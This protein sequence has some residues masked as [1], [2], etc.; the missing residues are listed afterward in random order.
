MFNRVMKIKYMPVM[1]IIICF[2]FL[3]ACKKEEPKVLT[4][5]ETTTQKA[6]TMEDVLAG[7]EKQCFNTIHARFQWS[8]GEEYIDIQVAVN[9]L[10]ENRGVLK[11]TASFLK[12]DMQSDSGHLTTVLYDNGNFYVNQKEICDYLMAMDEQFIVITGFF[13]AAREYICITG[14]DIVSLLEENGMQQ[15][16]EKFVWYMNQPPG[17]TYR[18]IADILVQFQERNP[19]FCLTENHA[20]LEADK[21]ELEEIKTVLKEMGLEVVFPQKIDFAALEFGV[22]E[23]DRFFVWGECGNPDLGES[24]TVRMD[25]ENTQ[26]EEPVFPEEYTSFADFMKIYN[27]VRKMFGMLS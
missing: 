4:E 25:F 24:M 27:R 6:I 9:K 1:L 13:K 2:L 23:K 7:I 15:E 18:E 5:E 12:G 11:I 26:F 16:P 20:F 8:L 10:S 3:V 17:D 21:S 22:L 19:V 14:D